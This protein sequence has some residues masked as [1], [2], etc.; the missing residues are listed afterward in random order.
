MAIPNSEVTRVRA[1][2]TGDCKMDASRLKVPVGIVRVV[3]K[4]L[5][6]GLGMIDALRHLHGTEPITL[7]GSETGIPTDINGHEQ[8]SRR[9]KEQQ[10]MTL[11]AT[12]RV[13]VRAQH[14]PRPC[15]AFPSYLRTTASQS[16]RSGQVPPESSPWRGRVYVLV[17][18]IVFS[19]SFHHHHHLLLRQIS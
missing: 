18:P 2:R 3:R 15:C 7:P 17:P 8:S 12:L 10:T 9:R 1:T 5:A 19:F 6:R 13:P 11:G 14:G 4:S 16:H